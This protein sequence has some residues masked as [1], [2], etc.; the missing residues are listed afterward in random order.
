MH[1]V[2]Q[3]FTISLL[4][5]RVNINSV[6][7]NKWK[8]KNRKNL[9]LTFFENEAIVVVIIQ[10]FGSYKRQG[11]G[12]TNGWSGQLTN[13]WMHGVQFLLFRGTSPALLH[14]YD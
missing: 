14:S 13:E 2:I 7:F 4:F 11:T 6:V 8:K 1:E 3:I 10:E 12:V 9:I 5:W